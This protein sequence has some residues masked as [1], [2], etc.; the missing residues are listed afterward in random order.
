MDVLRDSNA[1]FR[2]L[3]IA[4]IWFALGLFDSMQTVV[5]MPAQGMHHAWVK[6]FFTLFLGWMPL[7]VA[8]PGLVRLGQRYPLLSGKRISH[9][10]IHLAA[11]A[12]VLMKLAQVPR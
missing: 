9:W 10:A 7:V 3:W 8:T 5:T 11:C 12:V 4:S 2:W 1:R 6:L